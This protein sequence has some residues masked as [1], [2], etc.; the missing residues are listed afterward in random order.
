M[1]GLASFCRIIAGEAP[2]EVIYKGPCGVAFR[3]LGPVT[4]G[5]VLVV[6][7]VHVEDF[8][9]KPSVTAE[10]ANLAAHLARGM[11][12]ANLITS[13][14]TAATQTV[15][16]LHFHIVPRRKGDGLALPWTRPTPPGED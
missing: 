1:T 9:T 4:P 12:S 5:H 16:H 11:G 8:T 7:L 3:P 13:A 2:A 15:K 10:T 14:G 6:P